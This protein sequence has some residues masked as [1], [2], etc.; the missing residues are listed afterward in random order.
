[1]TP[2]IL[3]RHGQMV[4]HV[5]HADANIVGVDTHNLGANDDGAELRVNFLK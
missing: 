5:R 3:T 4:F 2:T 1:M